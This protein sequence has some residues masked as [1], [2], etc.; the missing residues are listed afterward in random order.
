MAVTA[1]F[2]QAFFFLASVIFHSSSLILSSACLFSSKNLFPPSPLL[3][4]VFSGW[5]TRLC[6]ASRDGSEGGHTDPARCERRSGPDS[7][8]RQHSGH[9]RHRLMDFLSQTQDSS[10]YTD[11]SVRFCGSSTCDSQRERERER[12]I[13]EDAQIQS[14]SGQP[15]V[16]PSLESLSLNKS[17]NSFWVNQSIGNLLTITDCES[18]QSAY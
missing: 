3:L 8:A 9:L 18:G 4:S 17:Y 16:K 12:L 1:F 13:C 10:T 5:G 14:L 11:A 7:D 15:W 2:N 6:S